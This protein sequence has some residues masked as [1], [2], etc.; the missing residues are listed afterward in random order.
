MEFG[1]PLCELAYKYGT[2]KC[3]QIYHNYTPL[4]YEMLKD[5][6]ETVKKVLELG[7]GTK[8]RMGRRAAPHY[9]T[10]A[11]LY[12]WRDFFPNAQVYG[13]DFLG[14][15]LFEAERI[16]TFLCDEREEKDLYALVGQTGQDIDLFVDDA[17]HWGCYQVFAALHLLPL[18]KKEVIY[19]IEDVTHPGALVRTLIRY[20]YTCKPVV[21]QQRRRMRP[22]TIVI[23][24]NKK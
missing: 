2:D 19:I 3:P 24:E 9:V 16:K 23:V 22:E 4:Y 17:N 1:T 5:K 8:G 13:A 11:S 21:T 7:I 18:F 14:S 20:G 15:A 6:R 12:M 10:G